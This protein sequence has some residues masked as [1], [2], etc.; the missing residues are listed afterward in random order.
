MT[1]KD[2]DKKIYDDLT[3]VKI[4]RSGFNDLVKGNEYDL[5]KAKAEFLISKKMAEKA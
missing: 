5:P 3:K 4:I 1:D 2:N